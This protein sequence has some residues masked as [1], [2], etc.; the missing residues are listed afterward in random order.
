MGGWE[1]LRQGELV[2]GT[3]VD[4][5]FGLHLAKARQELEETVVADSRARERGEEA[6]AAPAPRPFLP[7]GMCCL[8][9]KRL[10]LSR[11]RG[12]CS[13]RPLPAAGAQGV[14]GRGSE[15]PRPRA[16]SAGAS[17]KRNK[18]AAQQ[19]THSSCSNRTPSHL[20]SHM[21]KRKGIWSEPRCRTTHPVGQASSHI[22][23]RGFLA[24]ESW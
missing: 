3:T 8:S 6:G 9:S 12:C 18:F 23:Q 11:P 13:P 1:A 20:I 14:Q 24:S 16:S 22:P 7:L 19:L 10:G 5:R 2:S 15:K 4:A 17:E 21:G